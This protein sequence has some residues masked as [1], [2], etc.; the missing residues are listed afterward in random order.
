MM[1]LEI[2]NEL[3]KEAYEALM[4][5][6]E[7]TE[8][9]MQPELLRR[10]KATYEKWL[11]WCEDDR[12]TG[13]MLSTG[14]PAVLYFLVDEA[15]IIYGAVVQNKAPT[16]MGHLH[17]GIAPWY[18]GKG[19]GTLLLHLALERCYEQGITQVEVV[20]CQWNRRAIRVLE[21]SGGRLI[22]EFVEGDVVRLRYLFERKKT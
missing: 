14:V 7:E 11:S 3:H 1:R 17:A 4:E 5:R 12:T 21:K 6:W 20:T 18:R 19:Y 10:G 15:G 2:P 9:Q 13:S 8:P 16:H 22:E